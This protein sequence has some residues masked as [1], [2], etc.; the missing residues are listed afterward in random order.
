MSSIQP[1][2]PFFKWKSIIIVAFAM[3]VL[4]LCFQYLGKKKFAVVEK[5]APL[6][7]SIKLQINIDS[8]ITKDKDNVIVLRLLK[9]DCRE[10]ID[11]LFNNTV[12]LAKTFGK[13]QVVVLMSGGYQLDE[14]LSY[15]RLYQYS[16]NVYQVANPITGY[17]RSIDSY[18]FIRNAQNTE[19][20]QHPFLVRN[21]K[22]SGY[23]INYRNW[24][25]TVSKN[26]L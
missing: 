6:L 13:E 9:H 22:D 21:L 23:S 15:K 12:R 20:A 7:S 8:I 26:F 18:Y 10:C 11:S 4:F 16:L 14:F 17:D 19:F 1:R 5:A 2:K 24:F 25:D 3:N